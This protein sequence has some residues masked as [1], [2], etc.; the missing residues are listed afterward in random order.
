MHERRE[1]LQHIIRSTLQP[2][3]EVFRLLLNLIIYCSY[4]I[5]HH[6]D[7][8][9]L[10]LTRLTASGRKDNTCPKVRE[11]FSGIFS[12]VIPGKS[13]LLSM[14][15]IKTKQEK[16][17]HDFL[18]KFDFFIRILTNNITFHFSQKIHKIFCKL[19]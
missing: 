12:S 15:S 4:E 13:Y 16:I 6:Y 18:L 8:F 5:I 2:G 9:V 19:C 14:C 17:P 3:A 1:E 10:L 7:S 11:T